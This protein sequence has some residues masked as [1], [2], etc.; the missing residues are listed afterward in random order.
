[1]NRRYSCGMNAARSILQ[2]GLLLAVIALVASC[3]PPRSKNP[4]SDPATAKRD[5][6]IF[7]TWAGRVGDKSDVTLTV[8]AR[9][10]ATF[11]LVIL[12]DDHDNG[13][14]VLAFEGFPSVIGGKSYFNLRSKSFT[15][16]Y[17]EK[18]HVAECWIFARYEVGTDGVLTLFDM[19]EDPARAAILAGKLEGKIESGQVELTGASTKLAAFVAT[20][21]ASKLFTKFG[22]FK[23]QRMDYPKN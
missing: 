13:A 19:E 9:R 11:D 1:M 21:D 17:G 10:G 6:R 3:E 20:S 12:G 23:R 8:L 5:E 22:T 7:G 2:Q 14:V 18:S 15:G 16:D 4:L